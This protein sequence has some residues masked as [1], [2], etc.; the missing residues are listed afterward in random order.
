MKEINIEDILR[1]YTA[2]QKEIVYW[3]NKLR[4]L[5]ENPTIVSDKVYGS[6][7]EFPY[8]MR[9]YTIEGIEP[10]DTI[11]KSLGRKKTR[12]RRL[13]ERALE[14]EEEVEI[15]I[16]SIDD[17][18]TRQAFSLRYLDGYSWRETSVKLGSH[19]ES[20]ARKLCKSYLKKRAK[21]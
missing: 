4:D 5:E 2:L 18:I 3:R 7:P 9:S 12:I 1:Q 14:L 10:T 11:S 19:D 6:N 21:K 17:S 16:E 8:Q 20:Y 15:F 13:M